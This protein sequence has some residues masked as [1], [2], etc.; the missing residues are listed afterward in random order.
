MEC[1]VI[2]INKSKANK[3]MTKKLIRRGRKIKRR[4]LKL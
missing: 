3:R 1:L 4:S 2:G